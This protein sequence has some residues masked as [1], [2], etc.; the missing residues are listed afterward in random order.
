MA[1]TSATITAPPR[2]FDPFDI[3][4][5]FFTSVKVAIAQIALIAVC[6]FIGTLVPQAAQ[7]GLYDAVAYQNWLTFQRGKFGD[8]VPLMDA[9]GL[10]NIFQ[11]GYFRGLLVILTL[12]IVLCTIN[13]I[14]GIWRNAM[15]LPPI[16][17]GDRLFSVHQTARGLDTSA[18]PPAARDHLT[19]ALRARRYRVLAEEV[20]GTTYLYADKNRFGIFGTFVSHTGLVLLLTGALIGSLFGWRDDV[21]TVTDGSTREFGH[22]TNLALR[23]ELF[24]DEYDPVTGQPSD[25]Y[26]NAV[27]LEK[28]GDQ[29]VE[30]REHRIRVNTPLEYNGIVVHQA[31]FGPSAV[32]TIK[33]NQGNVLFSDGIP[34]PY[35]NPEGRPIGWVDIPAGRFPIPLSVFVVGRAPVGPGG[36]PLIQPGQVV[37]EVYPAGQMSGDFLLYRD[38]LDLGQPTVM[39]APNG[40]T[41]L[42]LSFDRERQFTG[43]N[44]SYNPG[45]P[46]IWTACLLM[47]AGWGAVFYFPHRRVRAIVAT[48]APGQTRLAAVVI[49]K[50][51]LGARTEYERLWADLHRRL[52][53]GAGTPTLV[54]AD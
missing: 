36:D 49:S 22:G 34:M 37:V 9:L 21:F 11:S 33:D 18:E 50:L 17:V 12:S 3:V 52:P 6:T 47:L 35:R 26:T 30:V 29:W 53:A 16:K 31:F 2:R 48:G 27:L 5:R 14:P 20:D 19:A 43:L 25:F 40:K 24:V 42:E 28:Q 7:A 1:N 44:L 41:I 38:L 54:G 32:L 39:K 45:L 8:L 23:N 13:R 51:D 15:G 4:W 46:I 10:F